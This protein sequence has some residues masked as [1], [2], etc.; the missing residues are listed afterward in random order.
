MADVYGQ[1]VAKE[2]AEREAA[3]ANPPSDLSKSTYKPPPPMPAGSSAD[4][5]AAGRANA[6]KAD[7][8]KG[9]VASSDSARLLQLKALRTLPAPSPV[10]QESALAKAAR[11]NAAKTK[12]TASK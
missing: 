2:K 7:N 4:L 11:E 9:E 1:S 6:P 8:K 12:K 3:K 5:G 10:A